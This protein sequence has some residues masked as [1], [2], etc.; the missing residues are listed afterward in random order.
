MEFAQGVTLGT[1]LVEL[2]VYCVQANALLVTRELGV[3]NANPEI[4]LLMGNALKF[5]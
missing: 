4:L 1:S 5:R 3:V 2:L